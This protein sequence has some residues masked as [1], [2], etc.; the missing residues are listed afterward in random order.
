MTSKFIST[1]T[2]LAS[3]RFFNIAEAKLKCIFVYTE[4]QI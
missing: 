4:G 3:A 1:K 2:S